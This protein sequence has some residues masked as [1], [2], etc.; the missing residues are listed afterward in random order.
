MGDAGGERLPV[1]DGHVDPFFAR[2]A[3]SR[4]GFVSANL[5]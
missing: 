5:G 3:C 2:E 4:D 1:G